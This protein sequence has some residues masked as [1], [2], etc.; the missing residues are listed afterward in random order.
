MTTS[1]MSAIESDYSC[2]EE[3]NTAVHEFLDIAKNIG[4]LGARLIY[5]ERA[6]KR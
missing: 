4:N 5:K 6:F 1:L 2:V 3:I